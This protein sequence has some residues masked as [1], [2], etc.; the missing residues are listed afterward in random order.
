MKIERKGESL[1]VFSSSS[2]LPHRTTLKLLRQPIN[3]SRRDFTGSVCIMLRLL[4]LLL[5][6]NCRRLE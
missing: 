5:L 6:G 3:N 2:S 1:C 4:L